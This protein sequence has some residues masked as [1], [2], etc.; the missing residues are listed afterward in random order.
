MCAHR[1]SPPFFF[2]KRGDI[3]RVQG[4]ICDAAAADIR[5]E[6]PHAV[7]MRRSSSSFYKPSLSSRPR[8]AALLLLP[9]RLLLNLAHEHGTFFA[10]QLVHVCQLYCT[11]DRIQPSMVG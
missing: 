11:F 6:R 5:H 4:L 10:F 3:R 2:W 1:I 7:L 8:G 9:T